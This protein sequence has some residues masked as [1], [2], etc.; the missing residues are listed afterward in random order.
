MIP[1][2]HWRNSGFEQV[3]S[4]LKKSPA[5]ERGFGF[6]LTFTTNLIIHPR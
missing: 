1:F 5:R 2:A 4:L 6:K 3:I